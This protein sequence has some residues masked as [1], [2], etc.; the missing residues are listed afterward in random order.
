MS[1][2]LMP[3]VTWPNGLES[4]SCRTNESV[5]VPTID[6]AATACWTTIASG[7]TAS[8]A[9]ANTSASPGEP[10]C[11]RV[12]AAD[13][14]SD[15]G[16]SAALEAARRA[17]AGGDRHG[18]DRG[19]RPTPSPSHHPTSAVARADD[20]PRPGADARARDAGRRGGA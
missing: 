7:V 17:G 10:D 20:G 3:S 16:H 18:K 19:V 6:A 1:P 11:A 9:G 8:G 14:D 12:R 2:T 15:R 5:G 13:A 4:M